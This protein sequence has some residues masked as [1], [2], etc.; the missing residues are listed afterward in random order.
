MSKHEVVV[1]FNSKDGKPHKVA[2][3][4]SIKGTSKREIEFHQNMAA[5]AATEF[6]M[7]MDKHA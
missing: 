6:A 7:N 5:R 3:S 4:Y 1:F 2:V